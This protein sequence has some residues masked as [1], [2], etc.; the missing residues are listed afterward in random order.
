M[1]KRQSQLT[2]EGASLRASASTQENDKE[3]ASS[4]NGK[5]ERC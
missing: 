1:I 2:I 3:A 4:T 5:C